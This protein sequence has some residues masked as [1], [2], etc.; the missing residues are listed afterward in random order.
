MILWCDGA[1]GPREN[2]RRDA[3]LLAYIEAAPNDVEPVLRL[4][5]FDPHGITLGASQRPDRELD[6]GRCAR[7]GIEWAVRPTGGRAIFHAEEW[8]YSWVSPI[9]HP[10]WGGRLSEVHG[11]IAAVLMESLRVLGV[12][13]SRAAGGRSPAS[14]RRATGPTIP[15]FATTTRDEITLGGRK[16]LG[17]AQRRTRLAWLQQGSLLLSAGH[18]R[19]ADYLAMSEPEREST[20][21]ALRAASTH[22]EGALGRERGLERWAD[23]LVRVLPARVVRLEG[24]S[25][26]PLTG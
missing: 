18:E 6:L 20:R 8:T 4:F 16:V 13:V 22:V 11:R 9:A 26:F 2:M 25:A 3:A 10:E 17:S 1:H 5:S 15:C 19:I 14:P 21:L 12:D 24:E 23:A 7:D